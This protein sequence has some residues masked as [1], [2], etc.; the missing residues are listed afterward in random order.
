MASTANERADLEA[1]FPDWVDDFIRPLEADARAA[2]IPRS[3]WG[4]RADS[5][6]PGARGTML[7][8]L[9]DAPMCSDCQLSLEG[10]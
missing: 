3:V 4:E 7:A 1:L 9:D 6:R 5:G 2:G 10:T 8:D